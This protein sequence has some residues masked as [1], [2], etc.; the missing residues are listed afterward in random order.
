MK[1]ASKNAVVDHAQVKGRA[2]DPF[3]QVVW[4]DENR[5]GFFGAVG[6]QD[7]HR[8]FWLVH[9]A[10]GH[11]DFVLDDS[12]RQGVSVGAVVSA[13]RQDQNAGAV[14]VF[15]VGAKKMFASLAFKGGGGIFHHYVFCQAVSVARGFVQHS[16]V[17][18]NLLHWH[19]L[20]YLPLAAFAAL[21]LTVFFVQGLL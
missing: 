3:V 10:D 7:A 17:I 8:A 18:K 11:V 1:A 15:V 19:N 5:A 16:R 21:S 2:L 6:L 14:Y 9:L 13:A 4:V 20:H 12:T